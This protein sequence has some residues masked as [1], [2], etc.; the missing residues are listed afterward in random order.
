MESKLITLTEEA[1][2]R[3][4]AAFEQQPEKIALRVEATTNG[5]SEFS[6]AMKLIG[7]DEKS[8]ED[9]LVEA[10]D[11]QVVLDAKSA[12]YLT[13]TTL[14][15]ED[16]IVKSGFKFINP[17]KPESPQIGSGPRPDLSG[18]LAERIQHLIE[19]E[20]NPAVAAHGGRMELVGVRD[21][22]VYLSFGGGCHGCGM[23]DVTLKQGVE[24]RIRE[25]V[26]EIEE[27]VDVTDHSAGENPY[28]S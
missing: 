26:P 7:P 20:L 3:I 17:N 6:Y 18:P 24:A 13:G 1:K 12:E 16:G 2:K 21:N 14:D 5:T 15:Y 10:G 8:A 23:V 22:K 28:Y 11:L 4:L 9:L 27:V 25:L 19:S